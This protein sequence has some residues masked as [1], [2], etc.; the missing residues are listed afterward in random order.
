M[1]GRPL[2]ILEIFGGRVLWGLKGLGLSATS[3][4]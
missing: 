1:R 2:E 4:E 3:M